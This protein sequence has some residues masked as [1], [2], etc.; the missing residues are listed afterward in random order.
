MEKIR[1]IFCKSY[2]VYLTLLF[3]SLIVVDKVLC[4]ECCFGID[5]IGDIN[6]TMYTWRENTKIY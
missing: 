5:R 6:H 2:R 1:M 4:T 3:I